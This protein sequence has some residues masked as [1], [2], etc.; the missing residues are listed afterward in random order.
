MADKDNNGKLDIG[1][2]EDLIEQFPSNYGLKKL[3]KNL[4]AQ[5]SKRNVSNTITKEQGVELFSQFYND[6]DFDDDDES[7]K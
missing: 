3:H 1:E 7:G 6:D 2:L 4:R 5:L